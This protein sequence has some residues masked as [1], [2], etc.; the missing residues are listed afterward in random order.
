M[1]RNHL[2]AS[3]T[4]LYVQLY[5]LFDVSHDLVVGLSLCVTALKGWTNSEETVSIFLDDDREDIFPPSGL[6]SRLL[7]PRCDVFDRLRLLLA[8]VWLMMFPW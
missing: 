2:I 6:L 7:M 1:T 4:A 3:Q 5:C 8:E